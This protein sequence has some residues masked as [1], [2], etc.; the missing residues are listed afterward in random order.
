MTHGINNLTRN[1]VPIATNTDLQFQEKINLVAKTKISVC[2]NM[3]HVMPKQ[4]SRILSRPMSRLNRAFSSVGRWN[5]MPQFKTRIHEAAISKTLNLVRRDEW[6]VIEDFY[7]P[8]TEFVYFDNEDDLSLKI[9]SILNNWDEY[10]DVLD[11]AYDKAMTYTTENFVS[12]IRKDI[13]NDL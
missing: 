12:N 7:E 4:K 3:V 2:Y 11:K 1:Y 13:E 6:N 10:S 8:E 9:T 5:V